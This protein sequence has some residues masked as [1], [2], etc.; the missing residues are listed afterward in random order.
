VPQ[1]KQ[2]APERRNLTVRLTPIQ[3]RR[4]KDLA[5]GLD[6]TVQDMLVAGLEPDFH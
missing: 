6:A 3:W 2:G 1:D 4:V 5:L